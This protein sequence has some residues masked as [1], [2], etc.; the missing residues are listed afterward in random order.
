MSYH[1][2]MK[3]TIL[4]LLLLSSC[5][6]KKSPEVT[7]FKHLFGKI[8]NCRFNKI[9]TSLYFYSPHVI[10]I[11]IKSQNFEHEYFH[12]VGSKAK[13]NSLYFESSFK[14][15][16]NFQTSQSERDSNSRRL[17]VSI[18][19]GNVYITAISKLDENNIPIKPVI[20]ECNVTSSISF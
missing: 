2:I 3:V 6:V 18:R 19:E 13:T 10:G 16:S 8:L 4:S 20:Y 17:K 11:P 5:N 7:Q 14:G 15:K 9:K 1:K 12:S